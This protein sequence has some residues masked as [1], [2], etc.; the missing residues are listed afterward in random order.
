MAAALFG[1]VV[2]MAAVASLLLAPAATVAQLSTTFYGG[3]CPSLESIVRSGMA[4]AVQQEM[5]M[6]ASILRL[7]FHDCFVNVR[8]STR[9]EYVAC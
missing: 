9:S 7:F 3:S 5:R 1:R 6:G 8:L 4:S 2:A